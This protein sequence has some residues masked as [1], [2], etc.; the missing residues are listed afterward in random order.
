MPTTG[1]NVAGVMIWFFDLSL[2]A[3]EGNGGLQLPARRGL[4]EEPWQV[5]AIFLQTCVR[6]LSPNNPRGITF[7]TRSCEY[8]AA[9]ADH[10][11]NPKNYSRSGLLDTLENFTNKPATIIQLSQQQ[12]VTQNADEKNPDLGK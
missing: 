2:C 8:A 1:M 4:R 7:V 11:S 12:C 10:R 6:G 5:Q 3:K 9:A